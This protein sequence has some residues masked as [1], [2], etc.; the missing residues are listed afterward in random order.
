MMHKIR[1]GTLT[2][3]MGADPESCRLQLSSQTTPSRNRARSREDVTS[4]RQTPRTTKLK[5]SIAPSS[6]QSRKFEPDIHC[7]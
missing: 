3:G 1:Q 6:I 5:Q 4:F 7:Y 2:S